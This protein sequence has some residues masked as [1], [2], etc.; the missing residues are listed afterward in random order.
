MSEVCDL[1]VIGA[2]VAGLAAAEAGA[3]AGLSVVIAEQ[4]MFG[5]LVVN[6][7]HLWPGLEGQP[8][9]GSD[10][11]S[12]M[13]ERASD[14]GVEI[15]FQQVTGVRPQEGLLRVTTAEGARLAHGVIVASGASLHT[16]EIP[17][18]RE[19][20][21]RGVSHCADCDAPL[22]QDQTVVVV[23]GGDSAL[24]EA[25]VLSG[26]CSRVHLVHRGTAFTARSEFVQKVRAAANIVPHMDTVVE[27]L[28]GGDQLEAAIVRNGA[29][30]AATRLPC[31]GFFAY[32]GLQPNTTF[33]ADI[34][35]MRDGAVV[36]DGKL[37]SS[38][39]G[40][41][42]IGAARHGH[43]GMLVHALTDAGRAVDEMLRR[44]SE[45]ACRD[46]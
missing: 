22:F 45:G 46:S 26:F 29:G 39:P 25:L 30:G 2:G 8:D 11:A 27:A 1:F 43:G 15:L 36:V 6:V 21:H 44:R 35:E 31:S 13:M 5:G 3:R 40:L 42:A 10:L 17:G 7:N 38:L 9:S 19:F 23:G 32:V 34:V 33:V 41:F 37:E 20:E 14:L 12:G 28:E 4:L 24:Q 18:E 16:L